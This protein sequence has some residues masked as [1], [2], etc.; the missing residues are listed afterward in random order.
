MASTAWRRS[1]R[2]G[3]SGGDQ[4]VADLDCDGAV[5]AGSADGPADQPAGLV[6][7]LATDGQ[8][9]E[10]HRQPGLDGV[11]LLVVDRLCRR[12]GYADVVAVVPARAGYASPKGRHSQLAGHRL[13]SQ[14][15]MSGSGR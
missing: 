1:F 7:D 11:P 5:A 8:G 14:V 15:R 13:L 4:V 10:H 9:I 2:D 6:V 3:V 12:P